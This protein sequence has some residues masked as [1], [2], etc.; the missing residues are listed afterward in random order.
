MAGIDPAS[1][2]R[3]FVGF[4]YFTTEE[5]NK[6]ALHLGFQTLQG[7]VR[8]LTPHE[9]LALHVDFEWMA[10]LN[11]TEDLERL[12]S[13]DWDVAERSSFDVNT[14]SEEALELIR[15]LNMGQD[16]ATGKVLAQVKDRIALIAQ[17]NANIRLALVK[18]SDLDDFE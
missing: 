8:W 10:N 4:A 11:Q 12:E 9:C 7:H 1:L 17:K 16:D 6:V 14:L 13:I 5:K 18:D 15:S 3:A 2:K